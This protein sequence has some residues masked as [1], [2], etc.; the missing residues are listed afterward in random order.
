MSTKTQIAN[1][2]M[3]RIGEALFVDVDT[4]GTTTANEFNAVWDCILEETLG[5]GPE[6]GWLFAKWD[7]S[8][9][10]VDNS[11]ITAFAD[12]S[13]STLV[14]S[15]SHGL[16]TG[17]LACITGTTSYNGDHTITKVSDD[18]FSIAV[19][20]VADDATGTVQ[21]TSKRHKFRFARPTSIRVTE[22]YDGGAPVVDWTRR[23]NWILTNLVSD[24]VE[25][26][27]I[28]TVADLT[29]TDFPPQFTQVMWRKMAIHL[30]YSRTQ[31][32]AL[33]DTLTDE[34]E[35]V[36]LPRAKGMDARE[37]YVQEQD[38]SWVLRGHRGG[39]NSG[40]NLPN[41]P[42]TRGIR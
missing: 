13:G 34:L 17:D 29:I 6:E 3:V 23:E 35:E 27:Y 9:V 15:A 12:N 2:T 5:I 14:T 8:D 11:A 19:T 25:M 20:F 10:N 41:I 26:D 42:G 24:D 1:L 21:W 36:Y 39:V 16:V 33:Q 32:K 38:Q 7:I 18:T 30:L 28:R 4:D 40:F 22:V 31:S 37:K